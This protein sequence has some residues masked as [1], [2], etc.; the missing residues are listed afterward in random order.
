MHE[1]DARREKRERLKRELSEQEMQGCSFR[2]NI[3][4][5]TTA[6][7]IVNINKLEVVRVPLHERAWEIQREKQERLQR[8]RAINEL[9]QKD[10]LFQPQINPRS[11]QM[12]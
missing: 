10:N 7:S 3:N 4:R 5:K 9:E 1:A 11:N 2:P 12:A 8:M 6:P